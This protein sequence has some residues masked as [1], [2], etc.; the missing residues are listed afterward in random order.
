MDLML[1]G[2]TALVT[3]GS[4]GIGK[5]VAIAL[6]KVGVDVAICPPFTALQA[7]VDSTRGSRVAIYAQTMHQA[8]QGAAEQRVG[9][10]AHQRG[11]DRVE[12]DGRQHAGRRRR[13]VG[14][15]AFAFHQQ[16]QR[17]DD[18]GLIVRE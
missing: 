9:V 5:G 10:G 8:D 11:G 12:G 15:K 4:E 16:A 17:L 3:G 18:V 2:K 1:H 13:R 6:A 14:L 7:M